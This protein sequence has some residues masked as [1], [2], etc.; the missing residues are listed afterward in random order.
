MGRN[1]TVYGR[2]LTYPVRFMTCGT[3]EV[4]WCREIIDGVPARDS[5]RTKTALDTNVILLCMYIDVVVYNSLELVWRNGCCGPGGSVL[6]PCVHTKPPSAKS[7]DET[8]Q[9]SFPNVLSFASSL[10]L[11]RTEFR[12]STRPTY[13][14]SSNHGDRRDDDVVTFSAQ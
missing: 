2:T 9:R 5:Y 11:A 8:P 3:R 7:E 13:K 1:G 6:S 14:L 4:C 12:L 10:Q